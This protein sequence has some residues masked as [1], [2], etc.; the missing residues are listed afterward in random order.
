MPLFSTFNLG[1]IMEKEPQSKILMIVICFLL[2]GLGIHRLM[3]GHKNWWMMLITLGGCGIW[4]LVD[5]VMLILGKLKMADG[6]D[7][8]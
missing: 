7:L 2:G 1:E 8:N 3:M 4:S 5:F 6:Q